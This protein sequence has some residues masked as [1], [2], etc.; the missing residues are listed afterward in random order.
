MVAYERR[1]S[2]NGDGLRQ[3]HGAVRLI[4][5]EVLQAAGV[6]LFL[7]VLKG[8]RGGEEGK[9]E[10]MY[11]QM[12]LCGANLWLT[13]SGMWSY[14]PRHLCRGRPEAEARW[15]VLLLLHAF[16]TRAEVEL[17]MEAFL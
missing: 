2:L 15:C 14:L 6:G 12:L 3:R 8:S 9:E 5:G 17:D 13:S 1:S 11:T 16:Y 4:S 10:G 7:S